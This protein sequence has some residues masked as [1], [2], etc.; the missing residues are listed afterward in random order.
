[1]IAENQISACSLA[2]FCE[3]NFKQTVRSILLGIKTGTPQSDRALDIVLSRDLIVDSSSSQWLW[4]FC[5]VGDQCGTGYLRFIWC[6]GIK[7]L[8]LKAELEARLEVEGSL[9]GAAI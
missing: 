8:R 3:D 2:R 6:L 9:G 5:E 4:E 1:M 7:T